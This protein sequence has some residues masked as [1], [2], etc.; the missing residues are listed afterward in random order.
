MQRIL[1]QAVRQTWRPRPYAVRPTA[2]PL[3]PPFSP[4]T[5]RVEHRHARRREPARLQLARE[6]SDDGPL[7]RRRGPLE[8]AREG[9]LDRAAR[10]RRTDLGAR[11]Q[12]ARRSLLGVPVAWTDVDL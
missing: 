1:F 4:P 7:A 5:P 6:G 3:P 10:L 11:R 9:V 2:E 12:A 8:R